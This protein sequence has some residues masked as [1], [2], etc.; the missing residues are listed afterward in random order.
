M[1]EETKNRILKDIEE[2]GALLEQYSRQTSEIITTDIDETLE[3]I[4]MRRGETVARVGEMMSDIDTACIG[5]TEQERAQVNRIIT[6]GHM[7]LGMSKDIKEI[8]KAAAKMRSA[9]IAVS[10]KEKQAA[11]RVDARVKELRS[12]LEAVNE[13]KKKVDLYSTNVRIDTRKGGSFDSSN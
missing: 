8:H 12:E 9:Y 6:S 11:L 1:T 7:S 13:D 10:D 2:I 5:C 3:D 4:V